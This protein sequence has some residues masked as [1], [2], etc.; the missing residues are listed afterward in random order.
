MI[1]NIEIGDTFVGQINGLQYR[2]SDIKNEYGYRN[3]QRI[4]YQEVFYEVIGKEIQL[5]FHLPITTFQRLKITKIQPTPNMW[6]P[7]YLIYSPSFNLFYSKR[8]SRNARSFVLP[9]FST[10][11]IRAHQQKKYL[12]F[13]IN[14]LDKSMLLWYNILVK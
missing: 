14:I 3:G 7:I 1:E 12:K 8:T 2:V 11:D 4:P 9:K 13:I 6:V 5:T 10:V